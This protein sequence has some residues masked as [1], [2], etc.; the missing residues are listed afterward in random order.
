MADCNEQLSAPSREA[1]RVAG[2][3]IVQIAAGCLLYE[4]PIGDSLTRQGSGDI[5]NAAGIITDT[6][7]DSTFSWWNYLVEKAI[8]MTFALLSAGDA[9][10]PQRSQK[11][12]VT[13]VLGMDFGCV[14]LKL[15][16]NKGLEK[17]NG[18]IGLLEYIQQGYEAL[19]ARMF[20]QAFVDIQ[21]KVEELFRLN[22]ANAGRLISEAFQKLVKRVDDDSYDLSLMGTL[23]VVKLLMSEG[24]ALVL[25]QT[26]I[27]FIKFI[28]LAVLSLAKSYFFTQNRLTLLHEALKSLCR[29]NQAANRQVPQPSAAV[30]QENVQEFTVIFNGRVK[31]FLAMKVRRGVYQACMQSFLRGIMTSALGMARSFFQD[32]DS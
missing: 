24:L 3:G 2:L 10:R 23:N 28:V 25:P 32:E 17:V 13:K 31:A 22:P 19:V 27:V 8:S 21:E 1:Y 7:F 29:Q 30:A 20:S 26:Y 11:W 15:F 12:F 9:D 4:E 6:D 16:L 14:A 5:V 18:W